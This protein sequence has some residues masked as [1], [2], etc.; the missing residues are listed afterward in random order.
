[1]VSSFVP[2]ETESDDG[3][4]LGSATL[5]RVDLWILPILGNLYTVSVIDRSN[6]GFAR[7]AGMS[8]DLNLSAGSRNIV[9]LCAFFI[10][11]IL[12]SLP[13]NIFLRKL[14]TP[15]WLAFCVVSWGLVQLGMAFV[16]S[17]GTLAFCRL[18][19]GAF[20]AGFLPG[21]LFIITTW[22]TRHEVQ[23]R[24]AVFY[25][26]SLVLGGFSAILE[27][28]FT[29]LG[30]RY[31]IA[32]WRWIFIVEGA[33]TVGLGLVSWHF[34]PDFPDQN[35]FLSTSETEAIL[36]R[37]EKD[38]GDSLPDEFTTQKVLNHLSDWKIWAFG[39]MSFCA[40]IPTY[41]IGYFISNIE[42]GMGWSKTAALLLCAPPYI[43]AAF[44]VLVFAWF[45]DRYQQR[46]LTIA[47]GTAVAVAGLFFTGFAAHQGLK[48]AGIFLINAGSSGCIPGILAYS[49][50]NV[51]SH[52]KRGVTMAL[53]VSFGG[54]GGLLATIVFRQVDAPR[55]LPGIYFT[56]ACQAL[57]LLLLGVM[58]IHFKER[59]IQAQ[60]CPRAVPNEG[61]HGFWFTL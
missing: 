12:L 53:V 16:T 20:E 50:N 29:L 32:G 40:A 30:G 2:F 11:F 47:I 56:L 23:Q 35:K 3:T 58:T 4:G 18:L 43:F 54:L 42:L 57:L 14:G 26:T 49:A 25:A 5:R 10:P 37:V 33:L 41:A 19:L 60:Q 7:V 38:R 22:Y 31:G 51:L 59:N 45:S 21:A 28:L 1:M 6:L 27:Y 13:S 15:N 55:Y 46:A 39:L 48:Y 9:I 61:R 8:H 34:V 36:S 24:I 44:T 17:W 52:T